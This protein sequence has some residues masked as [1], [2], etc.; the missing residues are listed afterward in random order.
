MAQGAER[1]ASSR[2]SLAASNG[3][4]RW[5]AFEFSRGAC[6]VPAARKVIDYLCRLRENAS[7]QKS[8][9]G[10]RHGMRREDI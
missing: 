1:S 8:Y 10:I 6:E 3:Q 9:V 5:I 4:C 7:G 2:V